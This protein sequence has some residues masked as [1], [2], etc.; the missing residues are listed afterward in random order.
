MSF[1]HSAGFAY[2]K[3]LIIGVG[4]SIVLIGALFKIQSWAGASEMLMVGLLVEAGLFVMLG[5]LPPHKDYY[6]EKLYPGLDEHGGRIEHPSAAGG[7][8]KFDGDA[9]NR[10]LAKIGEGINGLNNL[11]FDT[12]S[13]E[14]QNQKMIEAQSKMVGELQTMA[15]S[16]SSLQALQNADFKEI[17]NLTKG[18]GKFASA[19]NAAISSISE[20]LEDTKVYREQLTQM[21]KNMQALNNVYG[22]VLVAMRGK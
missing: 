5:L 2:I 6:W 22:G 19:L 18:A 16:M 7:G 9:L 21:N 17:E 4:A 1:V 10:S 8:S 20:S 14:G 3:N 12:S 13:L 15:K 11:S